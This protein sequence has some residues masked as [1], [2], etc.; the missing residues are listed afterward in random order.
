MSGRSP[1]PVHH[2]STQ[3][4]K[5]RSQGR[6]GRWQPPPQ[7]LQTTTATAVVPQRG[8]APTTSRLAHTNRCTH[9]PDSLF[10][11]LLPTVPFF[12]SSKP[13][14]NLHQLPSQFIEGE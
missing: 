2:P 11:V 14:S 9:N 4:A 3:A 7:W 5:Q 12:H 6:E 10:P 1:V 8:G 13:R